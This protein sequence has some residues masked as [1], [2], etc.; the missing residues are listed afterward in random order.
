[1]PKTHPIKI[2]PSRE[3]LL[4][5][6]NYDPATGV[7]TWKRRP[8]E[9]FANKAGWAVFNNQFA[10]RSAGFLDKNGYR[11]IK[12]GSAYKAHRLIWKWMTGEEPP[13]D[14]D[15]KDGDPNNNRWVNLRLANR[16]SQQWNTKVRKDN[17]SG[18]RG[19]HRRQNGKYEANIWPSGKFRHLGTFDTPEEASAAVEAARREIHG[20]FY[21]SR[22]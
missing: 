12:L 10:G 11:I 2:L 21:S 14:P 9:H 5:C 22:R 6:F 7:L 8:R 1:M 13:N 16:E 20:E 18:L 15:H 17:V 3:Y 4:A 19:V